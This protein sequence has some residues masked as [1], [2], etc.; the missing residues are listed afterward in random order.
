MTNG[1]A[2]PLKVMYLLNGLGTGGAERSLAD[3][4]PRLQARGVELVIVCLFRRSMGVQSEVLATSEVHFLEATSWWGR[5]RDARRHLRSLRPDVLHTTLFESDVI[6]RIAAIGSGVPVLSSLVNTSYDR[7]RILADPQ[8]RRTRLLAARWLDGLTARHLVVRFH[9]ITSAVKD[10]AIEHLRLPPDQI[11]VIGRGR[12][13]QRLGE[14]SPGRRQEARDRLRLVTQ[15]EVVLAVGRQEFQKGQ[16]FLIEAISQLRSEKPHLRLLIA[17]REGNATIQ[18][19]AAIARLSL[20]D[21]VS[22]LG[23]RADVGD[24]LSAADVFCFPSIYEGL[25][26]AVIEAM[27]M[28]TPIVATDLPALREVLGNSAILV[29]P[30]SAPALAQAIRHVLSDPE[31]ARSMAAAAQMRA[32]QEFSLD[33]IADQM[34]GLY[35]EVAAQGRRR[36]PRGGLKGSTRAW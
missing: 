17:G 2:A 34:A 15:D 20:T 30:R 16:V 27:E 6:G 28:G 31:L 14:R 4:L 10:A 7:A 5:I 12:D 22:L 33:R 8:L 21:Y 29:A 18:L 25:G 26:G 3:L 13:L 35:R 32:R 36:R 23:H 1:L 9:A 24:L 19:Q 11:A